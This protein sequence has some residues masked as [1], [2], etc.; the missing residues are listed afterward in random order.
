MHI[1]N[2]SHVFVESSRSLMGQVTAIE[3]GEEAIASIPGH[4]FANGDYVVFSG[5]AIDGAVARVLRISGDSSRVLLRGS[6]A[7]RNL[8]RPES[9]IGSKAYKVSSWAEIP[10]VQD[11]S[12]EGGEQQYYT[13]QC[14]NDTQEQRL[15]TF[16]SSVS[17]T[18]TYAFEFS[19]SVNKL[20]RAYD[21]VN[22]SRAFMMTIPRAG[23]V[24]MW[25]GVVSFNGI[26]NT[27]VNEMET[28][29]VVCALRSPQSQ[30]AE[31]FST[32]VPAQRVDV[33]IAQTA[34]PEGL[35]VGEYARIITNVYPSIATN[36]NVTL[37]V[38]NPNVLETANDGINYAVGKAIG[39]SEISAT[40]NDGSGARGAVG[41]N[42]IPAINLSSSRIKPLNIGAYHA[43][44]NFDINVGMDMIYPLNSRE[45]VTLE[46]VAVPK[47]GSANPATIK[48]QSLDGR[49]GV[50]TT[51]E[52][53][54]FNVRAMVMR[55]GQKVI[56]DQSRSFAAY[57]ALAN[58]PASPYDLN[59]IGEAWPSTSNY[60][61]NLSFSEPGVERKIM[62]IRKTT[63]GEWF[64]IQNLAGAAPLRI[65]ATAN[66][67]IS[68]DYIVQPGESVIMIGAANGNWNVHTMMITPYKR[69]VDVPA[70]PFDLNYIG[71]AWPDASNYYDNMRFTT[72]TGPNGTTTRTIFQMREAKVGEFLYI[73]AL[74]GTTTIRLPAGVFD[75]VSDRLVAPG[76]SVKLVGS[77]SGKFAVEDSSYL[78]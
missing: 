40:A 20:F 52:V 70:N 64:L 1:P 25:G 76:T 31:T 6:F 19:D 30:T 21:E 53:G 5:G 9:Y 54:L 51:K 4:S 22:E 2:G 73:T 59:Y 32:A 11:I 3:P 10:C 24:R 27:T 75:I 44:L 16:K 77:I 7:F 72:A 15:R 61:D 78:G 48:S 55:N 69:H 26:P 50:V 67:N 65:M 23:E 37:A 62:N 63:E 8:T 74:P 43:G 58:I 41:V 28:V 12:T 36:K 34:S 17:M 18:V 47:T 49:Q 45:K 42:V 71:T 33:S 38:S 68:T 35:Q 60:K 57:K 66:I 13:Y 46:V 39:M 29:S 56:A 14:L